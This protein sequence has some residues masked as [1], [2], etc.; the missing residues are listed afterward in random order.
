LLATNLPL[1]SDHLQLPV[2]LRGFG[3]AFCS[4]AAAP[5]SKDSFC[6]R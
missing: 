4:K 2:A 6:Q 5:F 3:R 1:F